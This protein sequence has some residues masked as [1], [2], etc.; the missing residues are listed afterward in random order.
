MGL[1]EKGFVVA[2]NKYDYYDFGG[3]F[4]DVFSQFA[5]ALQERVGEP[6]QTP[7]PKERLLELSRVYRDLD[8]FRI[9]FFATTGWNDLAV[10]CM[11][12][13]CASTAEWEAF[14]GVERRL[15]NLDMLSIPLSV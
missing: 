4:T 2:D 3:S 8:D 9:L 5:D 6:L 13:M 15:R 14:S 11:R 7:S 10:Q 1:Q 12:A